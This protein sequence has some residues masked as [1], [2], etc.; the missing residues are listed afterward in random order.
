MLI[1]LITVIGRDDITDIC[2]KNSPELQE[3]HYSG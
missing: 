1:R 3:D 2:A